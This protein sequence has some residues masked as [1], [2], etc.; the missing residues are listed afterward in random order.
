MIL[1]H[2][3]S[4]KKLEGAHTT[5]PASAVAW[6]AN[7]SQG[8]CRSSDG[9]VRPVGRATPSY[10]S[11]NQLHWRESKKKAQYIR[12]PCHGRGTNTKHIMLLHSLL[13][14][15]NDVIDIIVTH[16]DIDSRRVCGIPS[17]KL[18]LPAIFT[19]DM[20]GDRMQKR[21]ACWATHDMVTV[22]L[23]VSK[24]PT[25]VNLHSQQGVRAECSHYRCIV[26][27]CH[28][29]GTVRM[30]DGTQHVTPAGVGS[31][32][33]LDQCTWCSQSDISHG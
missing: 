13:A 28:N 9:V 24:H 26:M 27:D 29:D 11:L 20:L 5:S 10:G 12:P 7:S 14:L 32:M 8:R 2:L 22:V 17:R 4:V 19:D 18:Q 15:P 1:C 3:L 21:P 25:F 16:L 30:W 23:R 31:S 6:L 33:T